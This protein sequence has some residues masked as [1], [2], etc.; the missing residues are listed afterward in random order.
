MNKRGQLYL[1]SA[2]ILMGVLYT[3]LTPSNIIKKTTEASNM[4]DI[5]INFDRESTHFLNSLITT[6]QPIFDAF[7]NFTV[8]FSSYAKTKN[9]D[10]GMIYTFVHQNKLYIGNYAEDTV[11][12]TTGSSTTIMN[13][14]LADVDTSFSLA[15]LN[16][17]IQD[18]DLGTFQSCLKG[19]PLSS[20]FDQKLTIKITEPDTGSSIT[21]KTETAPK[22]PDLII[23]SKEKT[24]NTRRVYTKGKFI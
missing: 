16:I 19:V 5:A 2:L 17:A 9:Q 10:V 18:V 1:M 7:L 22:N 4:Q 6:N 12:V 8:L 21:L 24:A 15:G 14:C 20:D 3:L 13:G 23:I 11:V